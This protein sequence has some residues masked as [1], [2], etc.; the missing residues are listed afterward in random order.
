MVVLIDEAAAI[1]AS[2]A[3]AALTVY[4]FEL[5]M[6]AIGVLCYKL[7]QRLKLRNLSL[8]EGRRAEAGAARGVDYELGRWA[9]PAWERYAGAVA[10]G[11]AAAAAR[12]AL[13]GATA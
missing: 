1:S 9:P 6:A 2:A 10:A 5:W 8:Y 4:K 3:E 11:G 12:A 13:A 7:A